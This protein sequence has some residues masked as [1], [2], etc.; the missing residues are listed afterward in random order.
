MGISDTYRR[1]ACSDIII[2]R[3]ERQRRAIDT[4]GLKESIGKMGVLNPIIVS[5]EGEFIRLVA[6]ERRLTASMELG[7]TDI[8]VRFST[9][10]SAIELQLVEA[11]ENFK[12]TD[13]DWQDQVQA[14]ARIHRLYL[15]LDD[16]WTQA[17]TAEALSI[18]QGL[19]SMYLRVQLQLHEERIKNAASVREAYNILDRRDGRIAGDALEDLLAT[20]DGNGTGGGELVPDGA[21]VMVPGGET[22]SPGIS[23]PPAN[24]GPYAPP[25]TTPPSP[26][27][28]ETILNTSFLT[29]VENYSGGKFNLV[30]CDFPYGIDAFN[31]PQMMGNEEKAY[32]D[33]R[34]TY[35]QLLESFCKNLDKFMSLSGHLM[36]WYS[37][38]HHN[39]T[40]ET[41]RALAPSLDFAP[42]PLIW[43]KS[44]NA[45]IVSEP[46][47]GARHIYETCLFATRGKRP[48]VRV[49]SDAYSAPT[50][51]K[52]HPSTKPEP[53]LRHFMQM[54]VDGHTKMFDPTCGSGASIRAAESLGAGQT[55]GLEIDPA[56]AGPAQ[57]ALKQ[58]RLLRNS[59]I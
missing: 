12:R 49:V 32:V 40:M 23:I 33:T 55:L 46:R 4:K 3:D 25:T 5:M 8:P 20:P 17:E 14:V 43:V 45:G 42:F 58:A 7:L 51:V 19:V 56:F 21:R 53:M 37:A 57:A 35:V 11:E 10:L 54:L 59:G 31:G 50:D 34:D 28:S 52:L 29:W 13:L 1:V 41:F 38:K 30:H 24:P 9:D 44:N 36:F 26:S 16:E 15:G 47:H 27:A 39:L 2:A 18:T 48:I 22:Q 6:G